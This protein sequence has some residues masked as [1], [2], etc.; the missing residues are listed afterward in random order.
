MSNKTLKFCGDIFIITE[1]LFIKPC[2]SKNLNICVI[3]DSAI[4][5]N[6]IIPFSQ[7][8]GKCFKLTHSNKEIIIP[9]IRHST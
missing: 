9:L 3:S 6:V 2:N 7:V 8:R 4:V 1:P 5:N